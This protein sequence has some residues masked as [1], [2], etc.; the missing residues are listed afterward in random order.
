MVKTVASGSID[1]LGWVA[2][3]SL[4]GVED[5]P[6]VADSCVAQRFASFC[7]SCPAAESLVLI[8]LR[9]LPRTAFG[10]APKFK[11]LVLCRLVIGRN[12]GVDGDSHLQ[13]Q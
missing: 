12:S 10:N 5:R 11:K 8:Y 6:V 13:P 7:A 1:T 3:S 9:D 4:K 2:E